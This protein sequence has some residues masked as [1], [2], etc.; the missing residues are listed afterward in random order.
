[1][2]NGGFI[3]GRSGERTTDSIPSKACN[4]AWSELLLCG[5]P[6]V[7]VGVVLPTQ[8]AP[9]RGDPGLWYVTLS[10]SGDP[11]IAGDSGIVGADEAVEDGLLPGS[12]LLLQLLCDFGLFV[13]EVVFFGRVFADVEEFL[14]G[15]RFLFGR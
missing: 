15:V 9:L 14:L 5:T 4:G 11:V 8:G 7:Y 10:A 13:D 1:M 6:S 3:G 12:E 2:A